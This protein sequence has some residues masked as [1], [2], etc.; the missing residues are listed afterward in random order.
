MEEESPHG[1]YGVAD[2]D[3]GDGVVA[4]FVVDLVANDGVNLRVVVAF[5]TKNLVGLVVGGALPRLSQLTP[6]NHDFAADRPRK[7]L[8]R[9]ARDF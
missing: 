4:A 9:R 1:V 8:R 2:V 7:S 5:G 6:G 3:V